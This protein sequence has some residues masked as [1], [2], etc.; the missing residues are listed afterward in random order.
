MT[1][2]TVHRFLK[3]KAGYNLNTSTLFYKK[4]YKYFGLLHNICTEMIKLM[5]F[6]IEESY[7]KDRYDFDWWF[8]KIKITI[9]CWSYGVF[10]K[11]ISFNNNIWIF[12]IRYLLYSHHSK[13]IVSKSSSP[14]LV[15]KKCLV[16]LWTTI[17]I[18]EVS[19]TIIKWIMYISTNFPQSCL[20][21]FTSSKWIKEYVVWFHIWLTTI[22]PYPT[23]CGPLLRSNNAIMLSYIS[24]LYPNQVF[25]VFIDDS[26][27]Y[28]KNKTMQ[29]A[30]R[31][32]FVIESQSIEE[33]NTEELMSNG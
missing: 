8:K 7:N 29:I 2:V 20:S 31:Q 11:I 18:Q 28:E 23:R 32:V 3:T 4:K 22:N 1:R 25:M 14:L 21:F 6:L 27:S 15:K 24:Y 5:G 17:I 26:F 30:L 19:H 9:I 16:H 13:T 33:H 10:V 12:T